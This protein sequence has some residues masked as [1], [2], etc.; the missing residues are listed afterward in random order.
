[1]IGGVLTLEIHTQGIGLHNFGSL[2]HCTQRNLVLV[3]LTF[4]F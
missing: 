2:H 1:M 4:L 3:L